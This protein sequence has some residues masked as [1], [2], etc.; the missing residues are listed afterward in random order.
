MNGDSQSGQSPSNSQGF[1]YG[2]GYTNIGLGGGFGNRDGN[3]GND[4]TGGDDMSGNGGFGG[5]DNSYS[6]MEED[7]YIQK[8][9]P[10]EPERSAIPESNK[11][12]PGKLQDRS[13]L[14]SQPAFSRSNTYLSELT[15]KSPSFQLG[16]SHS[17][18]QSSLPQTQLMLPSQTYSDS[19]SPL[20][21]P[22]MFMSS[23]AMASLRSP[24]DSQSMD[25]LPGMTQVSFIF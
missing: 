11:F 10:I 12:S 22:P 23:V 20:Q 15:E 7:S 19:P 4:G 8:L 17:A 16:L 24:P 9:Y 13:Q 21:V 6:P 18:L 1:D 2:S 14:F 5:G 3:G 25:N